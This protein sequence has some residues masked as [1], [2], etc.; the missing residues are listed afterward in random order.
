MVE[1]VLDGELIKLTAEMKMRVE[2]TEI[3]KTVVT[4]LWK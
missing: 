4:V 2:R 1:M 3:M